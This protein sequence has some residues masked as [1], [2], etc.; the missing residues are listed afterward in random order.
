MAGLAGL[1][2]LPQHLQ[3]KVLSMLDDGAFDKAVQGAGAPGRGAP[4]RADKTFLQRMGTPFSAKRAVDDIKARG[5]AVF[6]H[7]MGADVA[8]T[9]R[10]G[11]ERVAASGLMRRARMGKDST[12]WAD[13]RARGD[14][15]I[16]F[17][18]L[19]AAL[20]QESD[21]AGERHKE[22]GE[23]GAGSPQVDHVDAGSIQAVGTAVQHLRALG[24]EVCTAIGGQFDCQRM[25]FQVARYAD[26][27]RYV[28]HSDVGPQTPDRRLTFILYLN[29]D[30]KEEDGGELRLYLPIGKTHASA[31]GSQSYTN[32]CDVA[33]LMNRLVMFRSEV[34]ASSPR[35][36]A[37][38]SRVLVT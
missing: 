24:A 33:P 34:L 17:N 37:S 3:L 21:A 26:G 5:L 4:V 14:D 8:L 13:T 15:M 7:V 22:A 35:V 20:E 18:D 6:D 32:A 11:V 12:Q 29:P 25:T 19:L 2:G 23:D 30:W 38:S 10:S 28:R 9:T 1:G 16:W 36:V 27:A 31:Q